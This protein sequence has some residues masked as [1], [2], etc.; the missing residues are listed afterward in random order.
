MNIPGGILSAECK[1]WQGKKVYKE[2][3]DQHFGYL[4]WRQNHAIQITF[5][6]NRGFSD[7]VEKAMKASKEH[8]NCITNSFKKIDDSYFITR[9]TLPSDSK[10]QVEVHHLLFDISI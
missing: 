10:K 5:S 8:P 6:T 1:F 4:T 3:I 2:T 7:V 9:N